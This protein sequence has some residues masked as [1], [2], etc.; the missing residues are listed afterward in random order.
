MQPNACF[1]CPV[2]GS[3][4]DQT[5]G[6][7]VL[8]SPGGAGRRYQAARQHSSALE[9]RRRRLQLDR[10]R[11]VHS[12]PGAGQGLRKLFL[13]SASERKEMAANGRTLVAAKF[14]WPTIAQ[15][16]LAVCK[17]ILGLASKPASV[18]DG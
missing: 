15:E 3:L 7:S 4:F 16:T 5:R 8:W 12:E 10:G 18:I 6:A 1:S 9:T 11:G 14:C 13:M 17:W 2:A